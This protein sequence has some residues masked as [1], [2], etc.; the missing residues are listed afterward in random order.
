[1]TAK[2]RNC[3]PLFNF[4][5]VSSKNGIFKGDY[6][7]KEVFWEKGNDNGMDFYGN[8]VLSLLE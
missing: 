7:R 6:T 1:M 2:F 3:N 4:L 5:E 8:G